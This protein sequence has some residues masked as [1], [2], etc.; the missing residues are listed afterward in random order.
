MP[1]VATTILNRNIPHLIRELVETLDFI[2][3][4]KDL[5]ILENGSDPKNYS[6][7]SNLFE[8]ETKGVSWGVNRLIG[9]C[10]D[11]GY[12]YI[13][14][15]C[16]DARVNDPRKFIEWATTS[17]EKDSSIGLTTA[18]W[19]DVW[20]MNGGKN[21]RS[22]IVSHFSPLSFVVSRKAIEILKNSREELTPFWDSSHFSAHLN[23]LGPCFYLYKAGMKVTTNPEFQQ[24]ETD[25][26]KTASARGFEDEEWKH[27]IGPAQTFDWI[28]RFFPEV[29]S[30]GD[31]SNKVKANK[32]KR[33]F[34]IRQISSM[35]R[36]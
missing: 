3:T 12:D 5:F 8:K 29:Q 18:Y 30:I 10:F 17:M 11:L 9:H 22:G 28:N 35:Y 33:D 26:P 4:D 25:T 1:K 6:R 7:Y 13:W 27:V 21:T 16:N 31:A 32:A 34:I 24:I 15:N 19:G 20:D 36:K 2:D 14:F 23:M